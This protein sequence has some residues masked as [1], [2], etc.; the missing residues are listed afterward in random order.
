MPLAM[1][2]GRTATGRSIG[3]AVAAGVLLLGFRGCGA[4]GQPSTLRENL[5]VSGDDTAQI[6]A[7]KRIPLLEAGCG[8]T[9]LTNRSGAP[10]RLYTAVM[11]TP[12]PSNHE[13]NLTIDAYHGPDTYD[14]G[15][16]VKLAVDLNTLS[17]DYES[18]SGSVTIEGDE[19]SGTMDVDLSEKTGS[20]PGARSTISGDWRCR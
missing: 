4:T 3:A 2:Y 10:G 19:H 8:P 16:G 20:H 9:N 6:V 13:V 11:E 18:V 15:H 12:E 1:G 5:T 17:E 7:A 14:I